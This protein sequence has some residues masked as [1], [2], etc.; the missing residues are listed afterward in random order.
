VGAFELAERHYAQAARDFGCDEAE[1]KR[2]VTALMRKLRAIVVEAERVRT[3]TDLGTSS[4]HSR[5]PN[6]HCFDATPIDAET[7]DLRAFW[8]RRGDDSGDKGRDTRL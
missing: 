2:W 4:D 6:W 8:T 5:D 7:I 3:D 1:T